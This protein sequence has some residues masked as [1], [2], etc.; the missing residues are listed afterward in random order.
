[1]PSRR[2]ATR[3]TSAQAQSHHRPRERSDYAKCMLFADMV[4]A[5]ELLTRL[6]ERQIDLILE[7]LK[8]QSVEVNACDRAAFDAFVR[9]I[10]Y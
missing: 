8:G 4:L 5:R 1:M 6:D 3:N 10:H 7:A 9:A 2:Q